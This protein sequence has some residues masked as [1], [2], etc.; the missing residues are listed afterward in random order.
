MDAR[1][2]ADRRRQSGSV[3]PRHFLAG[4]PQGREAHD[5]IHAHRL[6]VRAAVETRAPCR[7]QRDERRSE[8]SP[9]A[10]IRRDRGHLRSP[11]V[12]Q[13]PDA[14]DDRDDEPDDVRRRRRHPGA[15]S[16]P[17]GKPAALAQGI[18]QVT[19]SSSRPLSIPR[20]ISIALRRPVL[21]GRRQSE[22][23]YGWPT[24]MWT[25]VPPPI[26]G[27]T[28]YTQNCRSLSTAVWSVKGPMIP[29]GKCRCVAFTYFSAISNT[30]AKLDSRS[31][32]ALCP[33][34]TY[35]GMRCASFS[36][37]CCSAGRRT[38]PSRDVSKRQSMP[39]NSSFSPSSSM[40]E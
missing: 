19:I 34:T 27:E 29:G 2:P 12:G 25:F 39:S 3:S 18:G 31:V 6:V 13:R 24:D 9:R 32:A 37:F 16:E 22:F 14:L 21:M 28:S 8:F 38:W 7:S 36:V 1:N 23:P 11:D 4:D 5:A 15:P 35:S 30:S 40:G 26:R 17:S 10:E 33:T 20:R